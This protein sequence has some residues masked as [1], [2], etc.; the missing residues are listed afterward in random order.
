MW[1]ARNSMEYAR[2]MVRPR[3]IKSHLSLSLLPDNLLE[4]CKVIYGTR[5]MKDAAVSFYY[6]FKK[7]LD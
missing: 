3:M 7:E 5:N 6:N 1:Y 2:K 4:I